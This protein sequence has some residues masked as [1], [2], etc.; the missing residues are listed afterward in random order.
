MFV[1]GRWFRLVALESHVRW[2]CY[3]LVVVRLRFYFAGEC[4]GSA[5]TV[6]IELALRKA[7]EIYSHFIKTFGNSLAG[8]CRRA[9]VSR[10]CRGERNWT[11]RGETNHAAAVNKYSNAA[12][13]NTKNYFHAL[14]ED[15]WVRRVQFRRNLKHKFGF[16]HVRSPQYAARISNIGK[17]PGTPNSIFHSL[18]GL[19]DARESSNIKIN[20]R[21]EQSKRYFI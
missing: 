16:C 14:D 7:I 3:R 4:A 9:R 10:P 17:F 18:L 8:P 6:A 15:L 11:S 2:S 19:V 20:S 12:A 5:A 1:C 21:T 13:R